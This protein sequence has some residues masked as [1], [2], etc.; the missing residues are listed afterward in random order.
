M[1]SE[2]F[3]ELVKTSS[4]YEICCPPCAFRII[5][6]YLSEAARFNLLD[7]ICPE[8]PEFINA[9]HFEIGL[10]IVEIDPENL[11]AIKYISNGM[12]RV[13]ILLE[14]LKLMTE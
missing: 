9:F 14:H 2:S 13:M 7:R 3:L 12:R 1:K 5:Q 8:E 11:K 4:Q 6:S 10:N